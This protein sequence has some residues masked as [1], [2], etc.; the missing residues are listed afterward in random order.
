M[1]LHDYV[2][3]CKYITMLKMWFLLEE[4]RFHNVFYDK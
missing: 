2:K 4:E 1:I 3:Q